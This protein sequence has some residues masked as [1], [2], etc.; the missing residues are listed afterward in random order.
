MWRE[1]VECENTF[2]PAWNILL[3]CEWAS[4]RVIRW[5]SESS[6]FSLNSLGWVW[7]ALW[8]P[9]ILLFSAL[10]FC[11]GRQ[12]GQQRQRIQQ[13]QQQRRWP[14]PMTIAMTLT[15]TNA[16][17]RGQ[18]CVFGAGLMAP[19]NLGGFP[20]SPNSS[21]F[22]YFL[23]EWIKIFSSITLCETC[24]MVFPSL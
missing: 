2:I 17:L 23:L 13:K 24:L 6:F 22:I 21:V 15:K 12:R 7:I 16:I 11:V 10:M 20:T 14:R 8:N 19:L 9:V 1:S 5:A 18:L 4:V 3:I